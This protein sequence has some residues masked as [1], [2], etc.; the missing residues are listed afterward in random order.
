MPDVLG[1]IARVDAL[2]HRALVEMLLNTFHARRNS[3]AEE[4]DVIPFL[5]QIPEY[6]T[7]RFAKLADLFRL[8]RCFRGWLDVV[9]QCVTDHL[10]HLR[11]RELGWV[12][13]EVVQSAAI[14]SRP[15]CELGF[16]GDWVGV[17]ADGG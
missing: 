13:E 17:H 16:S 8:G 4:R 6:E 3:F 5:G 11:K 10:V 9:L 15:S 2:T 7:L 14:Y 1:D 12:R